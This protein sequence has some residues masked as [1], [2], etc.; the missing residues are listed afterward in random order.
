MNN[1]TFT[2]STV[3]NIET[4]AKP[5]VQ[6]GLIPRSELKA[7]VRTLKKELQSDKDAWAKDSKRGCLLTAAEV[8]KMLQVSRKTVFR[9][10]DRGVLTRV[11]L[12]PGV[13]HS[14]RFRKREV[15]A[16]IETGGEA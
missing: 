1:N 12:T 9:M 6:A 4:F 3:T 14:V 15:E 11:F 2:L 7:A 13:N 16:L 8:A 5:A 10:A